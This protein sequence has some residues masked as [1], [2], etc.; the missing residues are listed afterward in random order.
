V[1]DRR[2]AA[3]I[4]HLTRSPARP[5]RTFPCQRCHSPENQ[6]SSHPCAPNESN[7][8]R[9]GGN[10]YAFVMVWDREGSG[11]GEFASL[12][13]LELNSAGEIVATDPGNQR[14]QVFTSSGQFLRKCVENGSDD[15]DFVMPYGTG[16]DDQFRTFTGDSQPVTAWG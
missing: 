10:T 8:R 3:H 12:Q 6:G 2:R 1:P 13:H 5:W 15:G 16:I 11:N 9:T 14:V 7:G 4:A